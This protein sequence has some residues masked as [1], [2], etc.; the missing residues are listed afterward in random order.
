MITQVEIENFKLFQNIQLSNIQRINLISGRNNIGKSSILEALFLYMDHTS[1]DSFSKLNGFRG[2]SGIGTTGLWEPLF[3]EMNSAKPIKIK[4][5]EG[6][7]AGLLQ[8]ER[9]DNY[10]PNG[11]SGVPEDVLAQFRTAT[12]NTYSLRFRYIKDNYEENGHFSISGGGMLRDMSTSLPGNELREMKST[13]FINSII[14]RGSELLING[15][16]KLELTGEKTALVRAIQLLDPEI[17]D[18]VT[19]S[20]QGFTQLYARVGG[21]LLPLQYAGDGVLK[22]LAII[23]AILDRKNGLVLIDEIETGFHYSMYGKLWTI[24]D[25]ISLQS[26]CQVFATTHSYEL[27]AAVKDNFVHKNDFSY[28][29]LGKGKKGSTAYHYDYELL[30]DALTSEMEVR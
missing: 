29:R 22:L 11:I 20:V 19:L 2:A 8:Y 18:I 3:Y 9:D 21:K 10:L 14:A 13:Q 27:I 30:D 28:Y 12:K 23:I 7:K 17:E 16:G 1:F 5:A 26:N 25:Q 15:V 6:E 24:I 4:V